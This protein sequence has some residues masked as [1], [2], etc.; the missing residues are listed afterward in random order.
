M[1]IGVPM[2]AIMRAR[3]NC[4]S[5]DNDW[6]VNHTQNDHHQWW[7]VL[8]YVLFSS[9]EASIC[10]FD[11]TRLIFVMVMNHTIGRGE[12]SSWRSMYKYLCILWTNFF[13]LHALSLFASFVLL[14]IVNLLIYRNEKRI[15]FIFISFV[16]LI[17][18]LNGCWISFI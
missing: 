2:Q 8:N 1:K 5:L 11:L 6:N 12:N 4:I 3:N 7:S 14:L 16:S 13:A 18:H 9:L 17:E 15:H 10:T